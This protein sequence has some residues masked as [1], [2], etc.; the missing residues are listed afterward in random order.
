MYT[1]DSTVRRSNDQMS[2]Y[3]P[4]ITC[5][6]WNDCP[7]GIEL[8]KAK[9]CSY[10]KSSLISNKPNV[11]KISQAPDSIDDLPDISD[12]QIKSKVPILPETSSTLIPYIKSETQADGDHS[13][14]VT[15]K[16]IPDRSQ[17]SC[18][19]SI[20]DLTVGT[21]LEDV[22]KEGETT[23]ISE[24]RRK[25]S[26]SHLSEIDHG[27]KKPKKSTLRSNTQLNFLCDY[28]D[29][30][31]SSTGPATPTQAGTTHST[32]ESET[33][34]TTIP[35]EPTQAS[36]T[37][38]DTENVDDINPRKG[39]RQESKVISHPSNDTASGSSEPDTPC[40]KIKFNALIMKGVYSNIDSVHLRIFTKGR[41]Y[42]QSNIRMEKVEDVVVGSGEFV[43][44]CGTLSFPI[45]RIQNNSIEF[46]YRYYLVHDGTKTYEDLYNFYF[47]KVLLNR[48]FKIDRNAL[49][50]N[51]YK[52]FDMMILPETVGNPN[53]T[54]IRIMKKALSLITQSDSIDKNIPF[55]DIYERRLCSLQVLLP[56]CFDSI[57]R[58]D[59]HSL[60]AYIKQ[61]YYLV[62]CLTDCKFQSREKHYNTYRDVAVN[63]WEFHSKFSQGCPT[64]KLVTD[65]LISTCNDS[66]LS[67]PKYKVYIFYLS[68]YFIRQNKLSNE[69]LNLK[70]IDLI[71]GSIEP[72]LTE[73]CY[74]FNNLIGLPIPNDLRS[75]I[76]DSVSNFVFTK[77]IGTKHHKQLRLLP[78]YHCMNNFSEHPPLFHDSLYED[79]EYWGFPNDTKFPY[80]DT[81]AIDITEIT[82]ALN[83]VNYDPILPYSILLYSLRQTN[84]KILYQYFRT[85]LE[86][87][88]LSAFMNVLLFRSKQNNNCVSLWA[89]VLECLV[90]T[91]K[92]NNIPKHL[93]VDDINNLNSLTLTFVLKLPLS[94]TN[95]RFNLCL[96]LLSQGLMY[97]DSK[98]C[99]SL[100]PSKKFESFFNDFVVKWYSSNVIKKEMIYKNYE[101]EIE[102]WQRFITDYPFPKS[103]SILTLVE[104]FLL[105]RYK[106]TN[107]SQQYIIDLFLQLH[108]DGKHSDLLREIFLK[109]LTNR[110]QIFA[111]E[112]KSEFISR[113]SNQMSD[114]GQLHKVIDIFTKILLYEKR[115]FE[116]NPINHFLS[117]SSWKIYFELF[118]SNNNNQIIS[119]DAQEMLDRAL[120]EYSTFCEK[121]QNFDI[122]LSEVEVIGDKQEYFLSLAGNFVLANMLRDVENSFTDCVTMN[123]WVRKQKKSLKLLHD[124]IDIFH[125]I[126]DETI[127]SFLLTISSDNKRL[128]HIC[129]KKR[130]SI[131]FN[132]KYS[133]INEI[134]DFP[135]FNSIC[136]LSRFLINSKIILKIVNMVEKNRIA[137]IRFDIKQFYKEIW[138]P[139]WDS[140]VRILKE[141][142]EESIIISEMCLYFNSSLSTDEITQ[143]LVLLKSGCSGYLKKSNR[144]NEVCFK[145]CADKIHRYFQLQQCSEAA[146]CI[147]ELKIA[148]FISKKYERIRNLRNISATFDNRQLSQVDAKVSGIATKLSRL[149][150]LDVIRVFMNKI[151]FVYWIRDNLKDLNEVKTFVDIS[152]TTC[153]GNPVD[154]DRITCLSSVCTNFA[155]LIFRIKPDTDYNDLI[156]RCKEVIEN[157]EKNKGLT[158]LLKQVGDSISFWEEMKKSHGSVEETTLTQLHSIMNHGI[159]HLEVRESPTLSEIVRLRIS[160]AE[161]EDKIYKLEQLNEFRSKIMLVVSKSYHSGEHTDSYE[162][163]LLFTQILDLIIEIAKIVIKLIETGN[164][165]FHKYEIIFIVNEIECVQRL[166]REKSDL[167]S[168]L[169]CWKQKLE[170]ARVKYY[171]LNYYTISQIVS[172]QNGIASFTTGKE[173]LELEQLYHLLRLINQ[174]VTREDI[175]R[176]LELTGYAPKHHLNEQSMTR[177]SDFST[178][179]L[180]AA[181]TQC[182]LTSKFVSNQTQDELL[183]FP[184]TFSQTEIEMAQSVSNKSEIPL[185]LTIRGIIELNTIHAFVVSE[186]SLLHWCLSNETHDDVSTNMEPEAG[187]FPI[188]SCIQNSTDVG[189][190][191]FYLLGRILESIYDSSDSKLRAKRELPYPMKSDTINLVVLPSEDILNFVLSLYY[192]ENER[193]PLP[194]YHEV[195]VCTTQTKLEELEIF[196]RR[197]ML[198]S[199]KSNFYLFCLIGLENLHYEVAVRAV[200]KFKQIQEV[201]KST[202]TGSGYKLVLVCAEER[203]ESSYMAAAFENCKVPMTMNKIQQDGVRR[204]LKRR[205]CYVSPFSTSRC[206][207]ACEVDRD[208]YRV[209]LVVSDSVGAGKSRYIN[210]LKSVL[211]SQ[212]V[213]T[214]E[215]MEEAAVTVS[216]HGKIAYEEDLTDQ[217]L[218]SRMGV[219]EHGIMFH[220]DIASTVQLGLEL[221][222][223]KLIIL[224]GVCKRSGDF[225]HC[226]STDYYII[227]MTLASDDTKYCDNY[228]KIQCKQ[229][230]D[231]LHS[232]RKSN[233]RGN[234]DLEELREEKYQRVNHYLKWLEG[235]HLSDF[236]IHPDVRGYE[237]DL[238]DNLKRFVFHCGVKRPS[239]SEIRNFVTFLD[240]QLSD[241][242]NSDYCKSSMM[243]EEWNGFKHFVV[244]FMILMSRDFATPSLRQTSIRDSG[245]NEADT[246]ARFQIRARRRWENSS[247]PYIFFHPDGHTMTFLGFHVSDEGDL[248]DS[249][250]PSIVIEK[251]VME[252]ELF[253][254]LTANRV[255][256]RENIHLLDKMEKIMKIAGVMDIEWVSDPDHEYV[257]TL[258]NM[259]KILA[260]LMRFRCN[261][262]VVIMGETGCG[263]TRLIEFM[264]SLQAMPLGAQNMLILKVH[265]GTT[266]KDVIHKVEEAEKL[267]IRNYEEHN[268]DTILFFDEANT[269]Q[270]IGL[271]KEIMCDRR[272]YGRQIRSDVKLQFIAACNPYRKHSEEMLNKLSTAGLG[273]FTKAS[274]TFD[275]LGDIPLREL[276]YRVMELPASMRSFVWDFGQ[277]SDNI[278]R[279][280]TR[281]IVLKHVKSSSI[282]FPVGI[283]EVIS[284]VLAGAQHYMRCRKDECSFVS[285]RD[286]ERAMRVMIWFYSKIEYFRPEI[287]PHKISEERE[288]EPRL[289]SLDPNVDKGSNNNI[290]DITYSLIISLAVCY[291]ARLEERTEFD[292][293]I[294][295]LFTHPLTELIHE[296]IYNEVDKCHSLILNEMHIGDN[297]AKNTALKEN[298][299]MMFVC[300]ELKIPLFVIGKP[301]SSK[302][303]AKSIISNSMLGS[304][305]PDGCI[306][307]K[308]KQVQIMSFQCS[309]LSTAEGII[310]VFKSCRNLQLKTGGNKFVACVVLDEV[311]LAEDSPL[312]PLKVLHPLLEDKSYG[313]DELKNELSDFDN[314]ETEMREETDSDRDEF[315]EMKDRVAFI[316]ISNWSLDPAKMNRGIMLSRGDPDL[317]ELEESAKG[318]CKTNTSGAISN[319]IE[320][321][322][323]TLA[324]AYLHLTNTKVSTGREYFGLRDF[325]C[326]IKMLVF[327]CIKF[328]TNL[329]RTI[330]H[331][332]VKRNFGGVS[333][334]DP[335][336][337]FE[338]F[339]KLPKEENEQGPD[340][341]PLGL[342]R[343][344]L[345]NLSRSFHGETRYL[346]LLTENY[347]ALDILLRSPDMWPSQLSFDNIRVI[348]GSSFP[349][350]QEYSAVCRNINRIKDCMETGKT[351]ILLNLEN[352]YESLYDALNQYYMEMNNQRYVDLGLGT[353]RMKCRVHDEF[354]LIVVADTETVQERFPTPLINRLEKHFL[355]MS[356]VLSEEGTAISN[357]LSIWAK[358]F[359]TL[360][361]NISIGFQKRGYFSEGDCFI[362]YHNDTSSSI[363]FHVIKE[364]Y[365]N[366]EDKGDSIDRSA[367]LER[368][369]TTL[370][371]M[372]TAD[373]V[374]RVKNSQLAALSQQIT[375]VYFNLQL[376][377]LG[378]YLRHVLEGIC[379]SSTGAHLTLATT[380]SRLLTERD[381]EQL[382]QYLSSERSCVSLSNL[383]LQQFQTEQQYSRE[384]QE[385]LR[386]DT[387]LK[388][389]IL[390]V[391][392]ERGADNAK[393]IACAR[394]KTVD[395]LKDWREEKTEFNCEVCLVFLIQLCREAHGSKF[396]SFC[397]GDWNTVHI[398]DIRS[399]DYTELPP[400]S[401]LIGKQIYDLFGGYQMVSN[402]TYIITYRNVAYYSRSMIERVAYCGTKNLVHNIETSY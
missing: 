379:G 12:E 277:L 292:E 296:Q 284:E 48:Y 345:Q 163:S 148:L 384:I 215:E 298:V 74:E 78:I 294:V 45:N 261:I 22:I 315:D 4:S 364:M 31:D 15:S 77:V 286:V 173:D 399:L 100:I 349:C 288:F 8:E 132:P 68:C 73:K 291:R 168:I 61:F 218:R 67:D 235:H 104:K 330:L 337:V 92:N 270:A 354:K 66:T 398:D 251:Q 64:N 395:E 368:S 346:L 336:K 387:G 216:I 369:Q 278:E 96:E 49:E 389:K 142:S 226:K 89:E 306:L 114:P 302:S 332:V 63:S 139:V 338:K 18:E 244:K 21:K 144:Y 128:K 87:F 333:D 195:L 385:F 26:D 316:G 309:Q 386:K 111:P 99:D 199:D 20:V 325:Y 51:F 32:T 72:I 230:S 383:S 266:E 260:I 119:E 203:E 182:P 110:L 85:K 38:K 232:T 228:P 279:S 210:N 95:E 322:I 190:T 273:F 196:W 290:G 275:K 40:V 357:Q 233:N 293:Y 152:L 224:G 307:Q 312:L 164:Q 41:K 33:N 37:N 116:E 252:P 262:P 272:M 62:K 219:K 380:H 108:K 76:T 331:H 117:W 154:I 178:Q 113:L 156:A 146:A 147:Y 360:D 402:A 339:V 348:F 310:G 69:E 157:V 342:I 370:L 115:N 105:V 174:E 265:G 375:S 191:D 340:S 392:C 102:F 155:P 263:K 198:I 344:N 112:M 237:I 118:I 7:K 143:E 145:T 234:M 243:A 159:F 166:I 149:S 83:L 34:P 200:S 285:L 313:S 169:E 19:S 356:T 217:L 122:T 254:I 107:I 220:V 160:R 242:D 240:K 365:P 194:F 167:S 318:I 388:K 126:H 188:T 120:K 60:E 207:S 393:L 54:V 172:L 127:S 250:D 27:S 303:L 300:I 5:D 80:R 181:I 213:V 323:P 81:S 79:M 362:G 176:A 13:E 222:L 204:F 371:K 30:S 192:G 136:E 223:F 264:C 305:S 97:C 59:I 90:S 267:A 206:K 25:R 98:S 246:L 256:L 129:N 239:W 124:L 245:D 214:D 238:I 177:T 29:T 283:I 39:I 183:D 46:P 6:F 334:I 378:E 14:A 376:G 382:E 28:S 397:G 391:Q 297:I 101:Y 150:N 258:D 189:C 42:F 401:Y 328:N 280:Y 367:V 396:V 355:T 295:Q 351:I 151:S 400:I 162:K 3:C 299:F 255:N 341:S 236:T 281:E 23:T 175:H 205:L 184:D 138:V 58:K 257:L 121:I 353:H 289:I 248:I 225:W 274:D 276:V 187:Y 227:E 247:H 373:A 185:S 134:I 171:F 259:R 140:C 131:S 314:M 352:L 394:H 377:S 319:S 308:F 311:G 197:A 130:S 212:G 135:E 327:L 374:L 271:I 321:R 179:S 35:D 103:T 347:A 229:P 153:G 359:A 43:T 390:L 165:N 324:K 320:K 361:K 158:K 57:N 301:G 287:Y 366:L 75:P 50:N 24:N 137:Q 65:W 304:R 209:R 47:A 350:D 201:T 363:V 317:H 106:D 221:I 170:E 161:G 133:E 123:R 71:L 1:L 268:I 10:C 343:A 329:N 109:E 202:E 88:P 193:L 84:V 94:I 53:S 16:Q 36:L 52:Q 70:L 186:E 91:L 82:A 231:I 125:S 253:K 358:N 2:K 372:A 326:L 11:E 269:S 141:I 17:G 282:G 211:L 93:E 86:L 9:Y 55:E 335:F 180:S 381:V 241:C 208:R 56:S 44:L 249:D